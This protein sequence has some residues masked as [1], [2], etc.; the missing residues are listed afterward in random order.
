MTDSH[1]P[2]AKGSLF[3]SELSFTL[4]GELGRCGGGGVYILK[5]QGHD[6]W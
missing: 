3:P 4:E 5:A 2:W 1:G 6:A